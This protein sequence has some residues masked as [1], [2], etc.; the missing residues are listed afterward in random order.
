MGRLK[1]LDDAW[2]VGK[3]IDLIIAMRNC[4]LS[5][6]QIAKQLQVKNDRGRVSVAKLRRLYATGVRYLAYCGVAESYW[7]G[8]RR[9][10]YEKSLA[11]ASAID[12][13]SREEALELTESG[14]YSRKNYEEAVEIGE[15]DRYL[16]E[17][18]V[19]Y[20]MQKIV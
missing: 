7:R 18:E 6:S 19:T 16:D 2:K 12:G 14:G 15:L 5:E 10:E 3:F 11:L 4:G 17:N 13:K 1:M 9:K 20:T 8:D